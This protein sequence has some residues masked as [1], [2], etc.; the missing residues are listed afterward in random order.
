MN[1]V[2]PLTVIFGTL[3]SYYILISI[4]LKKKDKIDE[5]P[6]KMKDI[7]NKLSLFIALFIVFIALVYLFNITSLFNFEKLSKLSYSITGGF[8]TL[9]KNETTEPLKSY[10]DDTNNTSIEDISI[11]KL[12]QNYAEIETIKKIRENITVGLSLDSMSIG[13]ISKK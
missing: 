1:L 12:Q 10:F 8:K 9:K 3:I 5:K 4:D 6:N 13:E 11:E 7:L 2:K